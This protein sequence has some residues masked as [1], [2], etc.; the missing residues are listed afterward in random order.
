GWR[1]W[2]DWPDVIQPE[3]WNV[4]HNHLHHARLGERFDPDLVEQNLRWVRESELPLPARYAVVLLM[5][6]VWKWSYYAPSVLKEQDDFARQPRRDLER[7]RNAT[8]GGAAWDPRSEPGRRLWLGSYLPYAALHF[9]ALPALI[10]PLG[11]GAVAS[12]ALNSLAAELLT[13]LH[14][15]VIITTNHAGD[16]VYAWDSAPEDAQAHLLRQI[17]GSVNYRTGGDLNDLLHGW[18]NYQIEH[19]V[20]PDMSMLQYRRAQPKLKALCEAY[21]VPYVQESVWR[22]LRKTLAVMVGEE[23]MRWEGVRGA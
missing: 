5:A 15:F 3:A 17:L 1:R 4:E 16:D 9:G 6:S 20:W 7:G 11:P 10:A 14:T 22:R 18:L 12:A 21:G 2:L 23:S 19:H 13:N 8:L